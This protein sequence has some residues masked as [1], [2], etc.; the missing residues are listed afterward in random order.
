MK[1]RLIALVC[2][3][4][5]SSI[6][7]GSMGAYI[8]YKILEPLGIE[9]EES[10]IAIPFVLMADDVLQYTVTSRMEAV[11]NPLPEEAAPP[12]TAVT[13]PE[14][15]V[16]VIEETTVPTEPPVTEPVYQPV[17][18]SWFDDALFIGDSRTTGLRDCAR[19]GEADYFCEFSMTVFTVRQWMCWDY[20]E[21]KKTLETVLSEKQYG[22]VFVHLGLNECGREQDLVIEQYAELVDYIRE[23]Q[24]DAVIILQ[25][26]MPVS[27][28]KAEADYYFA[29]ENV[30]SLNERIEIL[31]EEKGC[32]FSNSNEWVTDE[33]GYMREDMTYDG[34][35]PKVHLY[36]QWRQAILED[37]GWYGIP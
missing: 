34:S 37:A 12:T 18:E 30:K 15:T 14:T 13:V 6:L 29:I 8:K 7:V 22:K 24:P 19:L 3:L 1:K 20:D 10:I 9:R 33:D 4:V 21:P 27:K 16:P 28:W 2:G 31:A 26:V 5:L 23:K 35:H 25:A 17:E 36:P 32:L 11:R